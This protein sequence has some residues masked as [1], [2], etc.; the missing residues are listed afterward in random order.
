MPNEKKTEISGLWLSWVENSAKQIV[1]SGVKVD[2]NL[3]IQAIRNRA[4]KGVSVAFIG[5]GWSGGNGELTMLL[6]EWAQNFNKREFRRISNIL[7]KLRDLDRDLQTEKRSRAYASLAASG[8]ASWLHFNFVHHKIGFFDRAGVW[9]GSANPNKD[10]YFK[11]YESGIFCLDNKL[12]REVSK[13]V[14][15]DMANSVPWP[16]GGVASE[17]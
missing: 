6:E 16:H 11:S 9:I 10:S 15:L 3:V 17:R 1:L 12:S 7:E 2:E 5:N 4:Q 14:E 13:M 8:V